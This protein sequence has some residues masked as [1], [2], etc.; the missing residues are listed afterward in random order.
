MSQGSQDDKE[1]LITWFEEQDL[2]RH[3]EDIGLFE[4]SSLET[5]RVLELEGVELPKEVYLFSGR[6]SITSLHS[7]PYSTIPKGFCLVR[8]FSEGEVTPIASWTRTPRLSEVLQELNPAELDQVAISARVVEA[9]IGTTF[10][11]NPN[12]PLAPI[13]TQT[14]VDLIV[15]M[16]KEISSRS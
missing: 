2:I 10:K 1:S 5:K 15:L 12:F 13:P 11:S 14:L 7:G 6:V 8:V 3:L 4:R 16:E 9:I